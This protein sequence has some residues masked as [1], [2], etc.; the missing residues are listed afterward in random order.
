MIPSPLGGGSSAG[1][2]IGI[3]SRTLCTGSCSRIAFPAACLV[4][5]LLGVP[6]G[7]RPRRGGRA[8]GLIVALALIG[9]YY[10]LFVYGDHTAEQGRIAPWMGVWAANIAALAVGL[11]FFYRIENIRKP[12]RI[13]AWLESLRPNRANGPDRQHAGPSRQLSDHRRHRRAPRHT[14][15]RSPSD[16]YRGRSPAGTR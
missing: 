14:A 4:F 5:A 3:R 6:L 8:A 16:G 13:L 9:G 2:W 12:S 1:G 15:G 7:V 10:F 11:V